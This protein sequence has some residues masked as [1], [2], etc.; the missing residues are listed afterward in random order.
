MTNQLTELE[1]IADEELMAAAGGGGSNGRFE[2]LD[3]QPVTV[4]SVHGPGGSIKLQS[5]RTVATMG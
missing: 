4:Q 2:L 3:R 1:T 5:L